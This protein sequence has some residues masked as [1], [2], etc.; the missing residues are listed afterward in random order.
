MTARAPEAREA[1]EFS[2]A[3]D[4]PAL[5]EHRMSVRDLAP[6][7]LGFADLLQDAH[8]ALSPGEPS[9]SLDIKATDEGSFV[10]DLAVI[11]H[12]A[13]HLLTGPD[14][15]S[16]AALIA[17]TTGARGVLNYF[18]N[19]RKGEETALPNGAARITLPDGTRIDFPAEVLNLARRPTVRAAARAVIAPLSKEGIEQVEVRP[20]RNS[21]PTLTITEE[22]VPAMEQAFAEGG[23]VLITDQP[24]SAVLTIAS[25]SFQDGKW[26][27]SD[28]QNTHWMAIEDQDFLGRIDR[29]EIRFGKDDRLRAEVRFRQWESDTGEIH[30]ERSVTQVLQHIPA[31]VQTTIDDEID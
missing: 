6:A 9:V 1:V 29:H 28:G 18:R 8:A 16:L 2:V 12:E 10:I 22:D 19:R 4:G 5:Q 15:A 20:Q 17:F 21:A 23:R 13:V 14:A 25:P 3:Y 30:A 27:L 26:R 24:Y 31:P 7:L 11:H